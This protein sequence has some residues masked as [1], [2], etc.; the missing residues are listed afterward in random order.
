MN[1]LGAALASGRLGFELFPLTP[2]GERMVE[3]AER[4]A[5]ELAERAEG[6]DRQATYPV[7]NIA[8]MQESGLLSACVPAELGG[9]G[10]ASVHDL[11]VGI[12]RLA[13]GDG[14]T[15]LAANMHLA[16]CW[17]LARSWSAARQAGDPAADGLAEG[18]AQFR[19]GEVLS[20]SAAAEAGTAPGYC[21]TTARRVDGGWVV[22]GRKAFATSSPAASALSVF[23]RA[24]DVDG[25][26][27]LGVARVPRGA[28]GLEICDDWDGL[29]MRASGSG[30]L[31][32]EG[33]F[34]PE[35]MLSLFGPLGATSPAMIQ[36]TLFGL[37]GLVGA[38]LGIAEAAHSLALDH[39]TTR[40]SAPS[41]RM[42]A[43]R[44]GV[45]H[46]VAESEIDLA[47]AR[48]MLQRSL[49]AI[50]SFF[51]AATQGAE[52]TQE[53]LQH[54]M[55]DFQ[56]TKWFVNRKAIDIV[57]RALTATGGAGYLNTHPLSRLYRDVRAGPFMQSFSPNEAFEYIGK[58]GLGL[59]PSLDG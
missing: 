17:R 48:A 59:D 5:G 15:A 43:E 40:Q 22:D 6:H 47:A 38:F 1:V 11:A 7:D 2:S 46:L 10:V 36:V 26:E 49:A 52:A 4:H 45:Q 55:K 29:G 57:D 23:V 37:P 25:Q 18:L 12:N 53:D 3:L 27:Q 44:H 24:V 50:D 21:R 34:V 9:L 14:S 20:S 41:G 33:C 51:V 13:R 19:D 35:D 58:V 31:V 56:C 42:M 54:L 30:N 16:A 39:V 32:L 28:A 8:D